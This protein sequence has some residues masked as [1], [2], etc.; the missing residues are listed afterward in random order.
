VL[1]ADDSPANAM[2]ALG[3]ATHNLVMI[4][5]SGLPTDEPG[6]QGRV[7]EGRIVAKESGVMEEGRAFLAVP[8]KG[9]STYERFEFEPARDSGWLVFNEA[10]HPDWRAFT[11]GLEIPLS[12]AVLAFSAVRTD[13]KNPVVFEF[14]P[15]WWYDWCAWTGVA[16]WM[17]ALIYVAGR[18]PVKAR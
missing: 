18:R 16:G 7:V 17:A 13:G 12:K 5:G 14:R 8:K 6:L 2:A 9:P 15:P 10:W 11:E 3:G 4:Q 1:A